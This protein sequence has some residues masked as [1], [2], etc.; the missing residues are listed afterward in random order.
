[1]SSHQH[2]RHSS[3]FSTASAFRAT[4]RSP[5]PSASPSSPSLASGDPGLSRRH[6]WNRA[7][8][9]TTTQRSDAPLHPLAGGSAGSSR[10][11]LGIGGY[12]EQ[13]LGL[14]PRPTQPFSHQYSSQASLVP[15]DLGSS[16]SDLNLPDQNSRHGESSEDQQWL[17]PGPSTLPYTS[18]HR[19]PYDAAGQPRSSPQSRLVASVSRNP[20]LRSVTRKLRRASVRVVNIMGKDKDEGMSRL[21]DDSGMDGESTEDLKRPDRIEMVETPTNRPRPEAMPP[22]RLR[23]RTLGM[24]GPNSRLRRAIDRLMRHPYVHVAIAKRIVVIDL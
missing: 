20:T 7:R 16:H 14:G 9:D 8:E 3:A 22:E 6:S 13:D 21:P 1:M 12:D 17:S 19:K 4:S 2:H 10:A 11:H 24:F 23:G 5:S 18:P 15:T